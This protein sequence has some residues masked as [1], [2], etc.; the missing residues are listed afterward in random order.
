MYIS[1]VKFGLDI[2]DSYG[3]HQDGFLFILVGPN[4]WFVFLGQYV[5]PR[6]QF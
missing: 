1:L 4:V 2:H 5:I 6:S 3:V